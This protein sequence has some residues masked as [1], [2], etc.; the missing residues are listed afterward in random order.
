MR[1][2]GEAGPGRDLLAPLVAWFGDD[3]APDPRAAAE[4]LAELG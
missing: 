3:P 1:D 2:S 4:L